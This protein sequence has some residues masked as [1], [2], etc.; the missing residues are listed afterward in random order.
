MNNADLY[1]ENEW[2]NH[3]SEDNCLCLVVRWSLITIIQAEVGQTDV[4]IIESKFFA[5]V[6]ISWNEQNET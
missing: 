3:T 2:M 1:Y 6:S 4:F 5:D